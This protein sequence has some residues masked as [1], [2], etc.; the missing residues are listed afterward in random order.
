MK[1]YSVLIRYEGYERFSVTAENEE[2]A[3]LRALE[4]FSAG[5]PGEEDEKT[6]HENPIIAV[7]TVTEE[8]VALP[9]GL[10]EWT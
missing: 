7:V 6:L 2:A 3:R 8:V 1:T 10:E 9:E 4:F 5:E